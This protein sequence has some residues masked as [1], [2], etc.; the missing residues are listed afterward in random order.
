MQQKQVECFM[1]YVREQQCGYSGTF[2]EYL[3]DNDL[4]EKVLGLVEEP[5]KEEEPTEEEIVP[6]N[7]EKEPTVDAVID[8][9]VT[10]SPYA[11]LLGTDLQDPNML[12]SVELLLGALEAL[13]VDN[14]RIEIEGGH[15]VRPDDNCVQTFRLQLSTAFEGGPC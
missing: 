9:A 13:H 7:A 1:A 4:E 10:G 3:V 5:D 8:N 11:S 14:A 6:K 15:E 2:N 12:C